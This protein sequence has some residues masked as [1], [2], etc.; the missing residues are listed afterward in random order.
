MGR[1]AR[2]TLLVLGNQADLFAAIR[3]LLDSEMLQVWWSCPADRE[4][5]LQACA[6]WPWG[7][8]GVGPESPGEAFNRLAGKPILWFWL[9]DRPADAPAHTRTHQRWREMVT[10]VRA[11]VSRSVGGVRLAPN[12]GLFAADGALILSAELEGLLSNSPMA[13]RM[14]SKSVRPAE[15]AITRH[16]LSVQL[17]CERGQTR[18]EGR[19]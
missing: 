13:I 14:S 15:R 17:L 1:D 11:C 19:E 8:A 2:R 10:D 4:D 18:L 5:T 9:G 3:P 16:Q 6:P 7:V 12:R